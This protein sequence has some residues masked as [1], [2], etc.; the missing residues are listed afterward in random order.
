MGEGHLGE[1][2]RLSEVQAEHIGQ[3]AAVF[4]SGKCRPAIRKTSQDL[5][6][7][8][9]VAR[10]TDHFLEQI[11]VAKGNFLLFRTVQVFESGV[12]IRGF[13]SHPETRDYM[14]VIH[15]S[16][17]WVVLV[18]T[19]LVS[20]QYSASLNITVEPLPLVER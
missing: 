3:S 12:A 18:T 9:P 13:E 4:V 2:N 6:R 1:Q 19:H 14:P 16:E 5:C 20:Q 15:K 10:R 8:Q 17:E 11:R 7:T